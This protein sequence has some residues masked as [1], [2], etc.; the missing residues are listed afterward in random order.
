LNNT[1]GFLFKAVFEDVVLT[2][3]KVEVK[4][5]FGEVDAIKF[6]AALI[7]NAKETQKKPKDYIR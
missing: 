5:T 7:A 2:Q 6:E 1:S 4:Q 3:M